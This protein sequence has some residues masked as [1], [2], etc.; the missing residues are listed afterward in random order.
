M[1][2]R[3]LL[4]GGHLAAL[5]AQVADELGP[6]AQVIRAERVRSGGIAGFFQREHYELTVEVPDAVTPLPRAR[7]AA[8]VPTPRPAPRGIEDLLDAADAA[9]GADEPGGTGPTSAPVVST[10]GAA[11]ADVL[12]QVRALAAERAAATREPRPDPARPGPSDGADAS[13][14]AS[15]GSGRAAPGPTSA[16]V[17]L[18]APAAP[19]PLST[20]LA[21]LGVPA[22]L[23]AREPRT[24]ADLVL[25]L[26][27]APDAPHGPGDVLVV[28][29][30]AGVVDTTATLLAD[31][32]GLAP[33]VVVPA[34]TV[35]AR[36][37]AKGR[38]TRTRPADEAQAQAWRSS[39]ARTHA[40][41]VALAVG[42]GPA[43]R[44]AAG[45]ILR[46]LRPDKTWAVVDARTKTSDASAWLAD[47][48]PVDALA[49]RGLFDTAE[50]GAV[51]GLGA[52]V[53]W[54]DGIPATPAAWAAAFDR[55]LGGRE[56]WDDRA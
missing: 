44:A 47:V 46:A 35:A 29:G 52:P 38:A 8:A 50:P 20:R 25:A 23:L 5:L 12:D 45:R 15:A 10:G 54:F 40:W 41:V 9:D 6:Q 28:A 19:E 49:V 22:A 13:D 2:R 1:A 24:L 39:A 42:E 4:E 7:R 36:A 30:P 56:A 14:A 21:R 31:R 37:A 51:L 48:G 34:G 43:E 17:V 11:F 55:A 32:C 27:Q 26:P 53:A 18:R 16:P 33:E 3:L